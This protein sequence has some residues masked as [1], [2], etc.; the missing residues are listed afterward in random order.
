MSFF[1]TLKD[2]AVE[3]LQLE[4]PLLD[5]VVLLSGQRDYFAFLVWLRHFFDLLLDNQ[6]RPS[7]RYYKLWLAVAHLVNVL[8]E[9]NVGCTRIKFVSF[10]GRKVKPF[11]FRKPSIG[12]LVLKNLLSYL[13]RKLFLFVT[14]TSWVVHGFIPDVI[15]RLPVDNDVTVTHEAVIPNFIDH[16]GVVL[17][18][19]LFQVVLRNHNVSLSR[20]GQI[21][22]LI[23]DVVQSFFNELPVNLENLSSLS[24]RDCVGVVLLR[25]YIFA[26]F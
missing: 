12:Q 15:R 16:L 9:S 1:S 3:S 4:L 23:L 18:A 5:K 19:H 21:H 24:Y 2:V 8:E 6:R 26:R 13:L 11:R 25:E 17:L 22:K 14:L 20:H 7:S 10:V